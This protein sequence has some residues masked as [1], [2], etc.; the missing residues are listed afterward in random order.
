VLV[1]MVCRRMPRESTH[2]HGTTTGT[3]THFVYSRYVGTACG[4][5]MRI[6]TARIVSS[7]LAGPAGSLPQPFTKLV[8]A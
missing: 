3:N 1:C 5:E 6:P 8:N 2:M 4:V 7:S